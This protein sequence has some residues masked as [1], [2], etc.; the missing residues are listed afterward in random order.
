MGEID[1]EIVRLSALKQ[2]LQQVVEEFPATA[3]SDA[4]WPCEKEFIRAGGGDVRATSS[5]PTDA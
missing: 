1:E 2:K 4:E 5:L 3:C